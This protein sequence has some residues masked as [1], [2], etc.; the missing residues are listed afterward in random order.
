[1]RAV[2]LFLSLCFVLGQQ[3]SAQIGG[4]DKYYHIV[5]HNNSGS[6]LTEKNGAL[7]VEGQS[8]LAMQYWQFLPTSTE[9]CYYIQNATTKRYIEACKTA[10]NN[11]YF[12]KT[13]DKPV[14]YFI[15]KE[16]AVGGAY[17]L[18]STNCSNYADTSK[19]P[20]GLNKDGASSNIIT[21]GA[22]TSNTGS[23]W[24]I[25]PTEYDYDVEGVA[26]LKRHT[27]FAKSSQV[28]FMPCGSFKAT[29][30]ARTLKV[31]GEGA[32]KEL[33]Y[34]CTT[35]GGSSSTT[36]TANTSTWWTLYTTDKGEV[37]RGKA[38]E[39]QVRFGTKPT[40]AY[41]AQVCFDW[42]HDGEFE[43]VQTLTTFSSR[44]VTFTTT[45]PADAVLGESRMRFRL[46]AD[47][48]EGPDEDVAQGQIL[49]CMLFTV[50]PQEATI[51][52]RANDPDRGAAYYDAASQTAIAEAVGDARFLCWLEGKKVVSTKAS[53]PV[54][55]DRPRSLTAVF[56]VNTTDV[57][58]D[59]IPTASVAD[60]PYAAPLYY[61]LT[62]R[63]VSQPVKGQTYIRKDSPRKGILITL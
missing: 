45:V 22:S 27:P 52:V 55:A 37:A 61:D 12:I 24:D 26:A 51:S 28:Y 14:E 6:Y 2:L 25:V 34:P 62:G 41:L 50:E 32:M 4:E 29:Y 56:S 35:W 36:G 44:D 42:N 20:V 9:G 57:R 59:G 58:P 48:E 11:T 43:D 7:Q 46:T 3:V 18:T 39:V 23:Y 40:S 33:D 60:T 15:S 10:A 30:C 54:V 21:W 16:T 31:T 63:Q 17:R 13:T 47:G 8:T 53:F 5:W 38:I 19:S 1:M 49:D